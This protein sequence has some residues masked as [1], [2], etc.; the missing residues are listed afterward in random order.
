[1][2]SGR[3]KIPFNGGDI[4]TGLPSLAWGKTNMKQEVKDYFYIAVGI[5][6]YSAAV[7]VFML[8]YGLTSGGVSG[9]SAIIYYA[10]G[11]EVQ[12]TYVIINACLLIAAIRELGLKFCLKTIF[13]VAAMTFFLWLIQR[14]LEVP[15]PDNPGQLILPRLMGPEAH[16]GAC[17]LGAIAEGVG[18]TFCFEH[19]GS[20]GGTDIIA[21]IVNKYRNMSLGTVLMVCDIIVITSCYFV[22]HDWFRVIYGYV[23][24]VICSFTLDYCMNRRHQ[25]VQFLIFSRNP[26]PIANAITKTGRGVTMLDGQGWYTHTERKVVLSIIRKREQTAMLR[27]IKAIDPYAFVSMSNAD[28]V[29]GEGFDKIKVSENRKTRSKH[30]LVCATDNAD[31]L[32]AAT[33]T[34][35]DKFDIRSLQ[36][37]GCDTRRDFY[38]VVLGQEPRKR[39]AFVKKFF[40]FDAFYIADD[41][42]VTFLQGD[43]DAP[44]YEFQDFKDI[45][46][47]RQY[48]DTKPTPKART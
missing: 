33:K 18:L 4:L 23:M 20:T 35:G 48:L 10:T 30:T 26:E 29:W 32:S 24:L 19:S 12:Y 45:D 40:G 9:V 11:F 41:G 7:T 13:G 34:L 15:D 44:K 3:V 21:A 16:F 42:H 1:M 28:G 46:S 37:V 22:F 6:I 2:K 27:M 31:K 14:L 43:Y 38:S 36:Q 5:F 17:V 39:V 47:L 25:S 8:P